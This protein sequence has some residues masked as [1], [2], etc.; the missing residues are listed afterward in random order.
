MA[1]TLDSL[2]K[3]NKEFIL[4]DDQKIV[5]EK[6]LDLIHQSTKKKKKV[7]I[8][9]GGPGTGKS[10]VA[11]NLLVKMIS[12]RQMA[13]YV[14]KN[15]AP[16][17]VFS[18]SLLGNYKKNYVG[19]LFKGSGGYYELKSNVYKT[20][21]VDE[22]H[23]LNEFSGL[24][25]NLGENQV[26]ELINSAES[27]V[28]FL[29]EDQKVTLK[30]IGTEDEIK[31]WAKFYNA[32]VEVFELKSQFR[33][34]GSNAYLSWLDNTLQV[35]ETANIILNQSEY[36][37][38]IF[39]NPNSLFKAIYEKNKKRNSARLVAGYCWDWISKKNPALM[40]IEFPQFKF[41]KQW[42]LA[43]D[44]CLYI[45]SPN[46]V[47]QIGCIHTCQ[48][49]EVEYIGVIIGEDMV[50]RNGEI[51]I[52]PTKR[53][54]TD[55]SIRGWKNIIKGDKVGGME[56]LNALVKNTYRTL[57]T[58]GIKGCYIYCVDKETEEWIRSRLEHQIV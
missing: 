45:N 13:Q 27:T 31:K 35:R 10:V 41:S 38:K 30:D 25:E 43:T 12:E 32:E 46:S 57:M 4:I 11:I 58:R 26:K 8:V 6:A 33:C 2:L 24:Y 52:D 51:I 19:G 50:V 47:H 40:D 20:L 42:N 29:D 1:E 36:E 18:D 37:F 5:Y 44:G 48:G 34:G 56:T 28:F 55:R 7:L 3:G 54:K 21:I 17:A 22:A 16:R 53:A 15:A 39:D 49:L 23:R 14:T 9:H